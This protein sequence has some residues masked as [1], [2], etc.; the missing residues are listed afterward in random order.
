MP[1]AEVTYC[2]AAAK[3]GNEMWKRNSQALEREEYSSDLSLKARACE[4]SD[5]VPT[6]EFSIDES[7]EVAKRLKQFTP[8]VKKVA[9]IIKVARDE[10]STVFTFGNGGSGSTAVHF[11]SDLMKTA[12]KS[13][14][15]RIRAISLNDNMPLT[16]AWANDSSY[17]RVF[18]EPLENLM[19]SGDVVIAISASGNSKNVLNAIEFARLNGG[20]TVGLTGFDGGALK[21]KVAVPV[22]VPSNDMLRIE[23]THLLICHLLVRLIRED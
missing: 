4:R 16:T 6:A 9:D 1:E 12:I 10:G 14:T 21:G 2:C 19:K 11:T 3:D 23:D 5:L 17:D 7:I 22:I 13:N 20:T 8:Q 15:K 18:Q